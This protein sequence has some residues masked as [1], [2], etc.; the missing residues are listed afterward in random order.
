MIETLGDA[1]TARW[2]IEVRCAWGNKLGNKSIRECTYSR[3]LD[4][5][6][7]T[8]TRGKDCPLD[9]LADRMKC[10][11]CNSRRVRLV[12]RGPEGWT[13]MRATSGARF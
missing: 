6:T 2:E 3:K 7:L 1:W 8:W 11:V 10:P 4:V 9:A 5:E 13:E 12:F